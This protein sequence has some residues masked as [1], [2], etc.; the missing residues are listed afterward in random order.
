VIE[1][2]ARAARAQFGANL[3][4]TGMVDLAEYAQGTCPGPAAGRSGR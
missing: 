2:A 4:A 3:V 1:L